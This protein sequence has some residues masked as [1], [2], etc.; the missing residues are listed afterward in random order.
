MLALYRSGRQADAL[1]AFQRAR[2]R[3]VE[4]LGIEPGAELRELDMAPFVGGHDRHCDVA[5]L[6]VKGIPSH[7]AA[8]RY[9]PRSV[10]PSGDL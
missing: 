6:V 3:L 7:W 8:I 1:A 10:I 2:E 4:E 9:Q 5:V